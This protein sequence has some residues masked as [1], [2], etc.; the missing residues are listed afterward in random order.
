MKETKR[1]KSVIAA[2]N[3]G[4]FV[5]IYASATREEFTL[6]YPGGQGCK[7]VRQSFADFNEAKA[8]RDR[9]LVR[10]KNRD[11]LAL[12]LTSR[13][14]DSYLAAKEELAG[15]NLTV[16]AAVREYREA[17]DLTQGKFTILEAVR[18]FASHGVADVPEKTAKE[19]LAEMLAAMEKDNPAGHFNRKNLRRYGRRFA[20]KFPGPVAKMRNL[21][22][23]AW[24]RTLDCSPKT[25]NHVA[26]AVGTLFTFA[27]RCGYLPTD[28]DAGK[29]SPGQR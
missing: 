19:V 18:Y 3:R 22:I 12:S 10:F 27:R 23:D 2:L 6:V 9:V 25:R 16:P 15:L 17:R 14:N 26:G 20:E 5:K 11:T 4:S 8:E 28:S 1:R 24:L 7:R 13:D 29:T 21:E